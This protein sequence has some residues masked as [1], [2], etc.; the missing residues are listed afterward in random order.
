MIEENLGLIGQKVKIIFIQS[1]SILQGMFIGVKSWKKL[2]YQPNCF[3]QVLVM[4]LDL[5]K[6]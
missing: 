6:T 4:A 5:F 3:R 2:D 1:S